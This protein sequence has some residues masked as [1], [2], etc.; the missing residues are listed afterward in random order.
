MPVG[1]SLQLFDG[2]TP[3]ASMS[4]IH[5]CWWDDQPIE[6]QDPLGKSKLVST[7]ASGYISLDLDDITSRVAGEYGWLLLYKPNT[8]NYNNSPMFFGRVQLS[9]VTSGVDMYYYDPE[10]KRPSDWLT[11]PTLTGTEDKVHLLVAVE[12]ESTQNGV[13]FTCTNAYT[14][15]WGDGVIE[16]FASG[17]IAT[18]QYDYTSTALNGT[19]T[20]E[21]FKQA[22]ITITPQGAGVLLSVSLQQKYLS[23]YASEYVTP[24]LDIELSLPNAGSNGLTIS[25]FTQTVT[26][27]RCRRVAIRNEG[28]AKNY[29]SRFNGMRSLMEVILPDMSQATSIQNMFNSCRDLRALP[30]MTFGSSM[31]SASDFCNGCIS[32]KRVPKYTLPVQCTT[33]ATMFYQ[34]RSLKY[35]PG[36]VANGATTANSMFAGTSTSGSGLINS[37]PIYL[38]ACANM[39]SMFAQ[40]SNLKV[41]PDI[42]VA[43]GTLTN[44]SSM[45]LN[46]YALEKAKL[47]DTSATTNMSNMFNGCQVIK[48]IP[49]YSTG[50]CTDFS[51]MFANCH[52]LKSVPALNMSAGTTFASMLTA[53]RSLSEFL[54]T[55]ARY[56][57]SFNAPSR[58]SASALNTMYTNLGT[59]AGAQTITVTGNFGAATDDPTIATAKGW[60]VTG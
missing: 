58:M 54:A 4:D 25:Q 20:S 41:Q 45:F 24:Y 29:N 59:A 5:A 44:A 36:I 13:A 42:Y 40:C 38:N 51:S 9:T 48:E 3:I 55:G 6:F 52:S 7:D 27:S 30:R 57:I 2:S 37:G 56:S 50:A 1:V 39:S 15:D 23:S 47:L 60:T 8:S 43:N 34:T 14:V 46:C 19:L 17:A 35:F 49:T 33:V 10:W 22:I 21:G 16:N 53:C 18:H 26:H 31:T 12:P 32:L 11:L 28:Q